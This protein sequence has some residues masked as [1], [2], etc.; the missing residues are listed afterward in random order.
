MF[1]TK[2]LVYRNFIFYN[3][4]SVLK[5]KVNFITGASGCGKSTLLKLFNRTQNYSAG[6]IL[7]NDKSITEYDSISL[8]S[9][10]RLISQTTFLFPG[11]IKENF[12]LYRKYCNKSPINEDEMNYFL[13]LTEA[14]FPLDNLSGE[15]SGGQR[16]RAYLAVCLSMGAQTFMLDEPTSALDSKLSN[17]VLENVTNFVKE[18]DQTLVVIS[19]DTAL[20]EKFAEHIIDL[21]GGKEHE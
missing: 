5:S 6:E 20:V 12:D 16:Q 1:T 2:N 13:R 8:R 21:N 14:D 3:D 11:T 4:I 18:N 15:L 19:H 7:Y 17:K 9:E 10:V